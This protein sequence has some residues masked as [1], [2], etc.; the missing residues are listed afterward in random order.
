MFSTLLSAIGGDG[1]ANEGGGGSGGIIYVNLL[2]SY[3]PSKH[4]LFSD[5]I[6]D[7]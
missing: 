6:I 3:L 2:R 5:S 4:N 1:S 7:R